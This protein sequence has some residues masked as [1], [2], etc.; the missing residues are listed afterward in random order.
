MGPPVAVSSSSLFSIPSLLVT[1]SLL[2]VLA[3]SIKYEYTRVMVS[4]VV[5][6]YET[7]KLLNMYWPIPCTVA[8]NVTVHLF[9][10][11]QGAG[12]AN[13]T[14]PAPDRC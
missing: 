14:G 7:I 1:S 3:A 4:M 11:V 12:R 10:T 8:P 5:D 13:A 6:Q 2:R 9:S